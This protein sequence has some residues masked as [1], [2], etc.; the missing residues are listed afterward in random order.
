MSPAILLPMC[1][2]EVLSAMGMDMHLL[3]E[4]KV[5]LDIKYLLKLFKIESKECHLSHGC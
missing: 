2:G 3:G 5:P 1:T 4:K